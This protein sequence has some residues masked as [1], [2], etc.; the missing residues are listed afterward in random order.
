M[1]QIRRRQTG[2]TLVVALILLVVL[3]LFATSSFNTAKTN[4]MVVGNMQASAEAANV[5]QQAIETT[6][7]T[8]QFITSPDNAIA[9]PCG[10]VPNTFCVDVNGDSI[11]DYTATLS[12]QPTCIYVKAI[13]NSELNFSNTED[14]GCA[15][16]Q[17]QTLGVAG[18]TSGDSLCSNTVWEITSKTTATTGASA[19]VI[20]GVGIRV[21]T[22]DA[23]C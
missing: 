3:T 13:K 8:T 9:N 18:S 19:T 15:A 17:Q 7:S 5:A 4:L 20:Q 16:G 11:N 12:P 14:L 21:S 22:D 10:G 6:L 23:S 2:S 1:T